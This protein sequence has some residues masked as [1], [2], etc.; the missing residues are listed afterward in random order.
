MGQMMKAAVF[1]AVERI[2]IEERPVPE[3]PED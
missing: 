3:C 1:K 2:E